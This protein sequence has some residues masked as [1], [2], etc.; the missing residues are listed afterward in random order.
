MRSADDIAVQALPQDVSIFALAARR[1]GL[2][3]VRKGLMAVE[4]AELDDLS[5]EREAMIGKCG[6]A[7]ADA[8]RV[9]IHH[10]AT[11]KKPHMGGVHSRLIER[12]ELNA[13]QLRQRQGESRWVFSALRG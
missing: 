2:P 8:P 6:F 12:P 10:A 3:D 9:F 11:D 13:V 1:H 7:K 4:S 5:V